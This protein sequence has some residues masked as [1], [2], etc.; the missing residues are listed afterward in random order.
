[1]N[2]Q[3][4]SVTKKKE[5]KRKN[6]Y[7]IPTEKKTLKWYSVKICHIFD[8]SKTDWKAIVTLL[9]NLVTYFR[10]KKNVS[11]TLAL[12]D[13]HPPTLSC[14]IECSAGDIDKNKRQP[15]IFNWIVIVLLIVHCI[16]MVL[17]FAFYSLIHA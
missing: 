16:Y 3:E 9:N 13:T 12:T 11:R 1:M 14:S 2:W 15:L 6:S 5:F 8:L 10:K 4:R 17:H 7:S